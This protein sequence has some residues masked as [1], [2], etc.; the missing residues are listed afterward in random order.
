MND[1]KNIKSKTTT[2]TVT[3][4]TTGKA[5]IVATAILAVVAS[6]AMITMQTQGLQQ[7][8]AQSYSSNTTALTGGALANKTVMVKQ[9]VLDKHSTP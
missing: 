4:T 6:A 8:F 3:T 9:S 2:K 7:V 1:C 5:I